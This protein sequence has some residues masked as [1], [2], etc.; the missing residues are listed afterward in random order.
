MKK[1]L[2]IVEGS[3][4]KKF[5]KALLVK[6]DLINKFAVEKITEGGGK[7]E[8]KFDNIRALLNKFAKKD[9]NQNF[10]DNVLL[11]CD[12]SAN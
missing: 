3:S 9:L 11:I 6:E 7:T 1:N 5:F 4:D 2:I 8:F 10:P 12:A